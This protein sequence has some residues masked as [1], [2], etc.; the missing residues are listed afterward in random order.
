MRHALVSAL[1]FVTAAHA[2]FNVSVLLE[3]RLHRNG[4]YSFSCEHSGE[5]FWKM[6]YKLRTDASGVVCELG[7]E[8]CTLYME[9]C[10]RA[11]FNLK[12][13]AET[14]ADK[15]YCEI[16]RTTPI[17]ILHRRGGVANLTFQMEEDSPL[18]P[19]HITT[20]STPQTLT[21]TLAV[22]AATLA[23]YGFIITIIYVK[24]R[25]C[26]SEELYD[27]LIYVP[28]Q[29]KHGQPRAKPR[30]G[31]AENS[32]EYMDMSKV[33]R[34]GRPTRDMNHNSHSVTCDPQQRRQGTGTARMQNGQV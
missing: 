30:K 10:R 28:M 13:F 26:R 27:S 29:Q 20:E 6:D 5:Q 33:L 3:P 34:G 25:I 23:L 15:L 19:C 14:D 32:E 11:R 8:G 31:N 7:T 22:V 17:P 12:N 4:S 2:D 1:L 21:W 16:Y 9:N 18:P 24:M